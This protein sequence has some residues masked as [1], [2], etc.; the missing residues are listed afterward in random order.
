MAGDY[1]LSVATEGGT[2][3]GVEIL[4]REMEKKLVTK[5]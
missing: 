1:S 3:I 5:N 2:S 4:N